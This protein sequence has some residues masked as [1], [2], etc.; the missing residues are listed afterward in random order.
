MNWVERMDD[1]KYWW[2]TKVWRGTRW[3]APHAEPKA[4]FIPEIWSSNTIKMQGLA[5]ALMILA[6]PNYPHKWRRGFARWHQWMCYPCAEAKVKWPEARRRIL[7]ALDPFKHD[8]PELPKEE[9]E[10]WVKRE[11]KEGEFLSFKPLE[12]LKLAAEAGFEVHLHGEHG[13]RRDC[14]AEK[15]PHHLC[16]RSPTLCAADHNSVQCC[17]C[18][19]RFCR[20]V[21]DHEVYYEDWEK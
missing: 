6:R 16:E 13:L 11:L 2:D 4:D 14:L 18:S 5:N 3:R 15:K 7:T 17:L 8:L 21:V 20:W 12:E 19:V 1:I 9:A 10:A